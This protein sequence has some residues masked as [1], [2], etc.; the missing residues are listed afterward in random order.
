MNIQKGCELF[1]KNID[2]GNAYHII[3]FS[4]VLYRYDFTH[5][6]NSVDPVEFKCEIYVN[7]ARKTIKMIIYN[8][9]WPKDMMQ[10]AID[11]E[12]F[13]NEGAISGL[14]GNDTI[15]NLESIDLEERNQVYHI[16]SYEY[17]NEDCY[18]AQLFAEFD[19][20]LNGAIKYEQQVRLQK[21]GKRHDISAAKLDEDDFDNIFFDDDPEIKKLFS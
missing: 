16:F 3:R 1:L 8:L 15:G 21:A 18:D 20:L 19:E 4:D 11:R 2:K 17:T 14:Y 13:N 5:K 7:M 6:I 9:D 12:F 10:N